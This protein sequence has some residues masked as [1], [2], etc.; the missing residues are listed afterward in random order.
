MQCRLRDLD[1]HKHLIVVKNGV[2]DL[3]TGAL[4]PARRDLMLTKYIPLD[5]IPDAPYPKWKQL[6]RDIFLDD[7]DLI[8]YVQRAF[9]YALT[10]ETREQKY[11]TLFNS[12]GNGKSTL[13]RIITAAISEY[14]V[15]V[16]I[17]SL[18]E[19]RRDGGA[20]TPE[21]AKLRGV[22]LV[23]AS[24]PNQGARLNESL[25]KSLTGCD[26]ISCR[27]LYKP[28][29]TFEPEFKLMIACNHRPV[30]RGTDHGIRRRAQL[31][32]FDA[33]FKDVLLPTHD[34]KRVKLRKKDVQDDILR[35]ELPGVLAWIIR[36]ALEW[37]EEGLGTAGRVTAATDEYLQ[38]SDSVGRFLD[39]CTVKDGTR[40]VFVSKLFE[41]YRPW[42]QGNG[43]PILTEN[44]LG[45]E[46]TQRGFER[47][48]EGGSR[49]YRG[50]DIREAPHEAP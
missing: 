25:V 5:Y 11:F 41:S 22:R 6:L 18:L 38:D 44:A 8:A 23:T 28:P 40:W 19:H 35:E 37:Y 14:A 39:E 9:G 24:E 50:L 46:L 43:E 20:A 27:D 17:E 7:D 16:P 10:G 13:L 45:R 26:P 47:G 33:E 2:V 12:G 36:G 3:R 48:K 21:L 42:A 30:I 4:Q 49:V 1:K 32:P 34:P 31:I 15:T 29:V